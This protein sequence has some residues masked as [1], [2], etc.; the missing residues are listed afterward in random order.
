[1]S[2]IIDEL[3]EIVAIDERI[4]CLRQQE[5]DVAE[6]AAERGRK[7]HG[8][9]AAWETK[10]V[11][12]ELAGRKVKPA[13]EP[14]D[15]TAR[16]GA[17][18]R[19]RA[20]IEQAVRDR[21]RAII[22]HETEI[23]AAVDE[24]GSAILDDA[25]EPIETLTDLVT[26][27]RGVAAAVDEVADARQALDAHQRTPLRRPPAVDLAAL[28]HAA[29]HGLHVVLV[30]RDPRPPREL[31]FTHSNLHVPV[32]SKTVPTRERSVPEPSPTVTV[33]RLNRGAEL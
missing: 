21:Q 13:P 27:L 32:D 10:A 19:I 12:D 15:D 31:G 6:R 29:A 17:L 26:L 7:Y 20:E 23:R 25:H 9:Y 33:H 1:M 4:E 28:L 11:E 30:G 8:E 18:G 16:N 2:R 3:P 14:P 5:R 24:Q 22:E